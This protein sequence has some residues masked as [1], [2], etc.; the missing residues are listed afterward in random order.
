MEQFGNNYQIIPFLDVPGRIRTSD[1]SLRRRSLYPAELQ[2]LTLKYGLTMRFSAIRSGG[3]FMIFCY[4]TDNLLRVLGN[5]YF[6]LS[7]TLQAWLF[8]YS[9][10][11]L[12]SIRPAA[13]FSKLPWWQVYLLLRRRML[14]P[15]EL[16]RLT[17]KHGLTMRVL[18]LLNCQITVI[19]TV[20]FF[21]VKIQKIDF[22]YFLPFLWNSSTD[23]MKMYMF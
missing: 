1:L 14:Y 17:L 15:T 23:E 8:T 5:F 9:D 20:T 3:R 19:S 4:A 11:F 7:P 16:W 22:L 10:F 2:R 18:G 6:L 12:D 13:H 21:E